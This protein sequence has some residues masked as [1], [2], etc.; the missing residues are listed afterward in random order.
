L[1]K[2]WAGK[3]LR[4]IKKG[5]EAGGILTA[6]GNKIWHEPVIKKMLQNEK[7]AADIRT[8]I[9]SPGK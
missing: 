3:G 7:R 4:K 8:S 2:T 5:L 9:L 1:P 6:T